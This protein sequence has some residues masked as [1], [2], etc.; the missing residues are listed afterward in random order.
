MSRIYRLAF[1]AAT[2]AALASEVAAKNMVWA[3]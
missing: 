1:L 3:I 2:L